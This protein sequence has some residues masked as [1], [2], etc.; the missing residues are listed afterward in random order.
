MEILKQKFE[1]LIETL[2]LKNRQELRDRLDNLVSVYPFNEYEFIIST[3]LGLEKLTLDD[4][5]QIRDEYLDRNMFL[6]IFE[7]SSPRGFG[8]HWAQ[9]HLKELV[10]K[11]KR[12]NRAIDPNYSGQYDLI[13]ET[14]DQHQ[15]IR[16]EVKASRAVDF[17]EDAP[18]Y[19]KALSYNSSKRFDMNFQQVKPSCCDVF[20]WVA[21]WRDQI[22]HWILSSDE[23]KQNKY[24]SKGQHRGNQGEGQIH[25][26]NDNI[27]E[28]DNFFVSSDKLQ[29]NIIDAFKRQQQ[30]N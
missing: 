24:Y 12:P 11:L 28:F 4:Y 10:P 2:S 27:S 14:E 26:R 20:V 5:Y 19:I 30:T 29:T 23:V 1:K 22:R 13:L 8:E 17:D 3:L 9:G 6:Y 16:V 18:L 21:V 7:I 25:I 15:L